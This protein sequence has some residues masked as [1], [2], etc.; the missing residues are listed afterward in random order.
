MFLV[1]VGQEGVAQAAVA[2][3]M[4]IGPIQDVDYRKKMHN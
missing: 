3:T 2:I 4:K 1:E